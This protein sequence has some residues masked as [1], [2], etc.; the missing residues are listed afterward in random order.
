MV[1]NF[2]RNLLKK[3]GA[4]LKVYPNPNNT[5]FIMQIQNNISQFVDVVATHIAGKIV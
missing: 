5:D 4:D 2:I 3:I 1:V